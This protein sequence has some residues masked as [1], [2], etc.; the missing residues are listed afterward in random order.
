MNRH[1][2]K[3]ILTALG[4][5]FALLTAM[6]IGRFAFTALLP[7]M[8][9]FHDFTDV[10]AGIMGSW[11][12][13]GY[14]AGVLLARK[15]KPGQR[16]FFLFAAF[17]LLSLITSAG[18]GFAREVP[19][20][21]TIRFLAGFASGM[22]F[23]LASSIVLDTL[24]AINRPVLSGL[25]YSGVGIGIAT[26]G[27]SAGPLEAI[28]GPPAGWL[29][30]SALCIP[31]VAV[32]IFALRP[33]RNYAPP[34]PQASAVSSPAHK[35]TGIKYKLLILSYFLEGF[36]YIIGM[37]FIVALVQ[38]V[39][40]SPE[41]ARTSWIVTGIAAAVSVPIWK[42]LAVRNG[43]LPM[44]ILAFVLQAVGALLPILSS[45]ALAAFGGGLLLG[46]TFMG[47]TTL[48]LQYGVLLSGKPSANAVAVMTAIYGVGQIIGP[49]V[50]GGMGFHI[51]FVI[52]AASMLAAAA[53]LFTAKLISDK[54]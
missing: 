25:L 18:M 37:T 44:L 7:G 32:S 33:S 48:S 27:L 8:M 2:N 20:L 34:L 21:H 49:V 53:I 9:S 35:K 50:A 39:T 47:I 22:C 40:N 28:G 6:G 24:S 13:V 4:G 11:N 17:L 46:G 19:L 38:N 29:G 3:G 43:Y 42:L 54:Q 23:V 30:M 36:G 45:S 5:A 1:E 51:A 31:L 41:I 10:T 52:S 15:E 16:R 14:L 26:S 12:F